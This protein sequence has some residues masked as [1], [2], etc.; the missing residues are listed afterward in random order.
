MVIKGKDDSQWSVVLR[1][2]F[3]RGEI[4]SA[5][6]LSGCGNKKFDAQAIEETVGKHVPEVAFGTQRH[7]YW[8]TITW[9]MPKGASYA[10][11][12]LPPKLSEANVLVGK[13]FT[14]VHHVSAPISSWHGLTAFS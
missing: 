3:F 9:T 1:C 10:E 11:P 14:L 2:S 12:R 6:I 8:R 7:E 4:K 5:K 13:R